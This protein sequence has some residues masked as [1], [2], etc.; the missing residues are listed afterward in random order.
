M[1]QF[2]SFGSKPANP[3]IER[4]IKR[5]K[6]SSTAKEEKALEICEKKNLGTPQCEQHSPAKCSRNKPKIVVHIE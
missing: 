3:V 5:A 2:L 4:T 1:L 6:V